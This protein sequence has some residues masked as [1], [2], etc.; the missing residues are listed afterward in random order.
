MI[1]SPNPSSD[2]RRAISRAS[3]AVVQL[4]IDPTATDPARRLNAIA[5][6]LT[7]SDREAWDA[8]QALEDMVYTR[9]LVTREDL[10]ALG[11]PCAE[12]GAEPGEWCEPS[13]TAATQHAQVASDGIPE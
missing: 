7:F 6:T 13:C 12:C 11:R 8:V 2:R 1:W 9:G 3:R 4:A 5:N 10:E